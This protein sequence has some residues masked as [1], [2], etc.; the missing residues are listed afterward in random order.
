MLLG[1][2]VRFRFGGGVMGP[3]T[4]IVTALAAGAATGLTDAASQLVKDAYGGLKALVMRRVKGTLAGEV[5]VIEHEKDPKTWQAPLAKTLTAAGAEQDHDLV[6][7]AQRL[8]QLLDPDGASAGAYTVTVTAEG[9][10]SVAAQSIY[11]GVRIGD[12]GT[13]SG[14]HGG[15][16]GVG[17]SPEAQADRGGYGYGGSIRSRADRP[18]R[19]ARQEGRARP[20]RAAG[21]GRDRRPDG[22]GA[23]PPSAADPRVRRT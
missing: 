14:L 18:W 21:P 12:T 19:S 16:R 8:L 10:H 15:P 1:R 23:K 9:H 13:P 3:V 17:N 5:A 4:L 20:R 22:W 7:A 11:G 2:P 6:E